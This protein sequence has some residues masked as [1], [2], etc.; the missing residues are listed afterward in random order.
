MDANK[1]PSPSSVLHAPAD[2]A[3]H[4]SFYSPSLSRS[5]WVVQSCA[6]KMALSAWPSRSLHLYSL[7]TFLISSF[8]TVLLPS[9]LPQMSWSWFPHASA[10]CTPFL[11]SHRLVT[12]GSA[13][14]SRLSV[15]SLFMLVILIFLG[16]E[17]SC[18]LSLNFFGCDVY[19]PDCSR[20]KCLAAATNPR[21][22][23][24]NIPFSPPPERTW[25]ELNQI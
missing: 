25:N 9:P 10:P 14:P 15:P 17:F 22:G 6:I 12:I 11:L 4:S 16:S 7:S 18:V 24:F 21:L 20:F 1:L 23:H 5:T 2:M 19:S 3:P 8:S 13:P